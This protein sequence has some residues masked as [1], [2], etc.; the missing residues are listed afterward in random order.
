MTIQYEVPNQLTGIS[1][2]VNTWEEALALRNKMI[3]D[4]LT[5]LSGI[6]NISILVQNED[7]SW[8]QSV[9]DNNGLPIP[10]WNPDLPTSTASEYVV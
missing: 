4:Y 3:T 1:E 8:T 7:G 6:F 9:A 10:V 2:R 5:N